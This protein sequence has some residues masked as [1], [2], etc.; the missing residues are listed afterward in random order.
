MSAV[1]QR[2]LVL[3][4]DLRSRISTWMK[5][6]PLPGVMICCFSTVQRR[7]SCSITWPA[8]IRFACCFIGEGSLG[9]ASAASSPRARW[10]QAAGWEN[11]GRK[12]GGARLLPPIPRH[13]SRLGAADHRQHLR[14]AVAQPVEGMRTRAIE[15]GAVA[16]SSR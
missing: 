3:L 7:P 6:P 11:E 9:N 1:R 5:A 12:P 14:D 15:I 4:P 10:R 13:S 16:F 8:R 2:S